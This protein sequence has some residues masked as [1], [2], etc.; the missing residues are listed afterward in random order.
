MLEC[1]EHCYIGPKGCVCPLPSLKAVARVMCDSLQP[2]E[3]ERN[4]ET[5]IAV[6]PDPI[7]VSCA[8][9]VIY[10]VWKYGNGRRHYHKTI[11]FLFFLQ[12]NEVKFDYQGIRYIDQVI[13]YQYLNKNSGK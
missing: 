3:R 5:A 10:R 2:K 12:G 13:I 8:T 6:L 1:R 11:C 9:K 4:D 7:D